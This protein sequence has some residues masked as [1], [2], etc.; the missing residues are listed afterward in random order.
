MGSKVE[1]GFGV[2]GFGVDPMPCPA[3]E[4]PDVK[5]SSC[6]SVTRLDI[7][8]ISVR[9]R[10]QLAVSFRN[11]TKLAVSFT[12]GKASS[13]PSVTRLACGSDFR[14][15]DFGAVLRSRSVLSVQVLGS[16]VPLMRRP[17]AAPASFA[18]VWG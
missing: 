16:R 8:A 5:A 2:E 1:F 9:N 17:A 15:T 12:D 4:T 14:M 10:S 13:C 11:R 18:C 3:D 7:L 6:P